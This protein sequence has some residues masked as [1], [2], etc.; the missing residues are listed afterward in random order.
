MRTPAE[1]ASEA[2][3]L[4][5]PPR[6]TSLYRR[7]VIVAGII[8]VLFTGAL[9]MASPVLS[10]LARERVVSALQENFASTLQWQ[11]LTVTVFPRVRIEMEASYSTGKAG[12]IYRR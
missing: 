6:P 7:W 2:G 9:W 4:N 10:R 12:P 5:E 11:R 8:V 1:P 3:V